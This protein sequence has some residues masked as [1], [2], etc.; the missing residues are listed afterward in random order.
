MKPFFLLPLLGLWLSATVAAQRISRDFRD[1]SLAEALVSLDRASKEG[2]VQFVYNELEDF[3]V[4]TSVRNLDL[5]EAVRQVV[6]FYP[7]R[8]VQVGKNLLLECT[9]KERTKLTGRLLDETGLP[10]PFANIALLH[11]TDST[12][13][14]GGVSNEEGRFVIP[15][16]G[17]SVIVRVRSLGHRT[18]VRNCRVGEVGDLRLENRTQELGTAVVRAERPVYRLTSEGLTTR[19]EGTPLSRLGTAVEV[20]EVLPGIVRTAEGFVVVGKGQPQV[21]LN[22]RRLQD[23]AELE[24][25]R[26]EDI[27][28]IELITAPGASYDATVRSVLRIKTLRHG[29][30]WS[31]SVYGSFNQKHSASGGGGGSF[32]WRKGGLDIFGEANYNVYRSRSEQTHSIDIRTA[33]DDYRMEEAYKDRSTGHVLWMNGGV[34][35]QFSEHHSA[36]ATYTMIAMPVSE[37]DFRLAENVQRNGLPDDTVLYSTSHDDAYTPDHKLNAYYNGKIGRLTVD[38]NADYVFIKEK[39]RTTTHEEALTTNRTIVADNEDRSRMTA[40]KLVVAHPVGKANVEV[41]GEYIQTRRT[42][43]YAISPALLSSTADRIGDTRLAGFASFSLPVGKVHLTAGGRYEYVVSDYYEKGVFI[44]DQSRRYANFFPSLGAAFEA[45]G[46]QVS[47]TY[48]VKTRR[49]SYDQLSSNRQYDNRFL[50]EGGNPKLQPELIHDWTLRLMRG[51]IYFTASFQHVRR[52][53]VMQCVPYDDASP[54]IVLQPTN[55]SKMN[56]YTLTLGLSP[57][58]GAWQPRWNATLRGQDLQTVG[59]AG[60]VRRNRPRLYFNWHN[61]I[62]LSHGWSLTAGLNSSTD[63]DEEIERKYGSWDAS[64]GILWT[65]K[66]WKLQLRATDIFRSARDSFCFEGENA[67]FHRR[68][69]GDTQALVL[70]AVYRFNATNSKYKGTGAGNDE[71]GRL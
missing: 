68:C 18:L 40:A 60:V 21:Y 33:T 56:L 41:G 7:V 54:I 53:I 16:G 3:R 69:Y 70:T 62:E 32:N 28:S 9:Q 71:K 57:R 35:Y 8:I 48:A 51:W 12:L 44:A 55:R 64:A 30:G 26:A 50:Y 5:P 10:V 13:L 11:P 2:R 17:R 29:E 45:K 31:G 34:N 59:M 67:R 15:V 36:G 27:A 4:T 19:V 14:A 58:I 63:G 25:L 52:A 23:F 38:F 46:V 20:I 37:Y 49:P 47:A 66:H 24:R 39:S 1:V 22:G 42:S 61:V 43:R 65:N 6:G